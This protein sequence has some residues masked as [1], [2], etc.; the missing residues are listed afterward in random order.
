M[1]C[2]SGAKLPRRMGKSLFD[3]PTPRP[4]I[5]P[6]KIK[7]SPSPRCRRPLRKTHIRWTGTSP[8][9]PQA[10][11]RLPCLRT[12]RILRTSL[13][14]P[15]RIWRIPPGYVLCQEHKP[16]LRP[17]ERITRSS[18]NTGRT[19]SVTVTGKS[20]DWSRVR[21]GKRKGFML[22]EYI[23][24]GDHAPKHPQARRKA[25]GHKQAQG[26]AQGHAQGG[27]DRGDN[28]R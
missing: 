11:P 20:G 21:V 10:L 2:C 4:T 23:K 14:I 3:L 24:L 5:A 7:I 27:G 26:H 13:S 17:G 1:L 8:R 12:P 25:Q 22:M 28:T 16:A 6:V 15:W 9:T 18:G 19:A